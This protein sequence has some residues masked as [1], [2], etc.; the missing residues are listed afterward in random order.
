[1]P[2]NEGNLS[3]AQQPVNGVMQTKSRMRSDKTMIGPVI[4]VVLQQSKAVLVG[5]GAGPC[6][7][8]QLF[9]PL[10]VLNDAATT[11]GTLVL[12]RLT[13]ATLLTV[14]LIRKADGTG[15]RLFIRPA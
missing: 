5:T 12:A 2:A 9:V 11:Y 15:Y 8:K 10:F 1:M 7:H 14:T 4:C 13:G 6:T 3:P